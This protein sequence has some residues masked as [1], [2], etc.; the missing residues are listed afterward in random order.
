MLIMIT[1]LFG[2]TFI[3]CCVSSKLRIFSP[4]PSQCFFPTWVSKSCQSIIGKLLQRSLN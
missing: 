1:Y 2:F 4:L 3:L